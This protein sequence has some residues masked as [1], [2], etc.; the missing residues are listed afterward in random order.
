MA[1]FLLGEAIGRH[2][3]QLKVNIPSRTVR[4]VILTLSLLTYAASFAAFFLLSP[5]YRGVVTASLLFS[6]P[7]VV[8]R[9]ILGSLLNSRIPSFP[10]GTFSSNI[11]ATVISAISF[12]LQNVGPIKCHSTPVA[13]LQG[14]VDGYTGCLSTVS[15]FAA[16]IHVMSRRHAWRYAIVSCLTAQV[17]L[18]LVIGSAKWSGAFQTVTDC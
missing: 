4:I 10:I 7:G 8:T 16:E 9:H 15:T 11:L 13:M 2:D 17:V 3:L 14:V 12:V 6:F 18:V 1:A 5:D